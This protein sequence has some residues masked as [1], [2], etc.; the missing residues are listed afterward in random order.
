MFTVFFISAFQYD[1]MKGV[2][3]EKVFYA[4]VGFGVDGLRGFSCFSFIGVIDGC[5]FKIREGLQRLEP[6]GEMGMRDS[7]KTNREHRGVEYTLGRE[8]VVVGSGGGVHRDGKARASTPSC[9]SYT[10]HG[11]MPG[12]FMS[13]LAKWIA[14]LCGDGGGG[15]SVV[16]RGFFLRG[17]EDAEHVKGDLLS[18]FRGDVFKNPIHF[19]HYISFWLTAVEFKDIAYARQFLVPL[20]FGQQGPA[21]F[22]VHDLYNHAMRPPSQS[23][24]RAGHRFGTRAYL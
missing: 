16:C 13:A 24:C 4:G 18:P 14:F 20:R 17:D 9:V 11:C 7:D 2:M 8:K 10:A 19:F 21:C 1:Q 6:S 15:E 23:N 3:V 5:N 22:S 12:F